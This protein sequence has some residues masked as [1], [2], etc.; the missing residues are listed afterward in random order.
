MREDARIGRCSPPRTVVRWSV[1]RR[2]IVIVSLLT[3][4]AVVCPTAASA[5][6]SAP[7]VTPTTVTVGQIDDLSAPIPGLFKGAEDGTKA[8]FAYVN[9]TGGV[10][11]RHLILDARDSAFQAGNVTSEA[12]AIAATDFA[13]VGG[14]EVLDA[15]EQPVIDATKLPDIAY[16]LSPSLATDP[17]VYNAQPSASAQLG[18]PTGSYTYF[19]NTFPK[20]V[21]SVGELYST[22]SAALWKAGDA[23][24]ESRGW[25]FT[26]TRGVGSGETSFLSDV[27]KMKDAGVTLFFTNSLVPTQFATL[28]DEMAQEDFHPLVVTGGMYT[29]ALV[30]TAGS[31]V[32]GIYVEQQWPMYYG[33]DAKAVPVVRTYDKWL[34][35]VDPDWKKNTEGQ[36]PGWLNAALFVQALRAAGPQPTRE[37]LVAQLNK[38]TRF[39]ADGMV[40]AGNPAG[41]VPP[42]CWLLMKIVKGKYVRTSPSPSSGYIC[43]PSGLYFASGHPWVQ[44]R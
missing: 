1:L 6:A 11:G 28:M 23:A 20:A 4:G 31:A 3:L 35:K 16:A 32:D 2:A 40:A 26:Y 13:M 33:E 21:K 17:N 14:F 29:P 24:A 7:G 37:K 18:W 9:S 5:D 30:Q 36:I 25:R 34:A 44:T 12:K 19:A 42:T 27:I 22:A 15:A 41:N 43:K 38:I 8:Y 39:D 10:N